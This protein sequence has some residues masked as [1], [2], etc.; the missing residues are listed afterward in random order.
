MA[1]L[2]P[3]ALV[4]ALIAGTAAAFAV[5]ETLKTT[6]APILRT[7]VSK[8]FSPVCR[9]A[10]NT[11]SVRFELRRADKLTLAIQDAAGKTVR[12]LFTSKRTP[13]GLHA[14]GWNGR[15][16]DGTRAPDGEYRPRVELEDAD[17]VIVLPNRIALDTKAP[18]V[19]V[20][21][22]PRL[23]AGGPVVL[24]Y[25]LD[26][27]ARGILAVGG[28]RV[29]RT[30]R[31]LLDTTLRIPLSTLRNVGALRGV[32]TLA[33]EDLAGNVSKPVVVGTR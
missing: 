7:K 4:L 5:T 17:R 27:A 2:G 9:C 19:R 11:A 29:A 16:D 32:V 15:R 3:I 22:T 25:R 6:T 12:V 1:R 23:A 26:E 24:R 30:H 33:A 18:A 20:V 8:T 10:T 13:A 14:F 28:K 21:G 31:V